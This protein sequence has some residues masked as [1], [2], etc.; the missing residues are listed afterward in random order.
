MIPEDIYLEAKKIITEYTKEQLQKHKVSGSVSI[1]IERGQ[2]KYCQS[3]KSY[4]DNT[5]KCA[6]YGSM[7]R[8]TDGDKWC[9]IDNIQSF[10]FELKTD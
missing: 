10:G 6:F 2:C 8:T 9:E 4:S 5:M 3:W 7:P 1:L